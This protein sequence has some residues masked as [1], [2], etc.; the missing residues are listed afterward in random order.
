[1]IALKSHVDTVQGTACHHEKRPLDT[2]PEMVSI[3]FHVGASRESADVTKA[4]N[5]ILRTA[6]GRL[7]S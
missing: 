6:T 1:M 5:A 4:T 3:R 7:A 2:S